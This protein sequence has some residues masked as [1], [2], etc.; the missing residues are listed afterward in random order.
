MSK[1]LDYVFAED[2]RREIDEAKSRVMTY[3]SESIFRDHFKKKVEIQGMV[4]SSLLP[5]ILTIGAIINSVYS[6]SLGDYIRGIVFSIGLISTSEILRNNSRRSIIHK[7]EEAESEICYKHYK[8]DQ[9]YD[10]I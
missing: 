5:N 4:E 3:A 9:D 8:S 7:L 1:L 6:I 2:I 10:K